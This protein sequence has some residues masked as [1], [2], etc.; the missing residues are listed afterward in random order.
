MSDALRIDDTGRVRTMF[1]NRP[2][3]KNALSNDP[4]VFQGR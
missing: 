1:L 4:P 3:K 2:E